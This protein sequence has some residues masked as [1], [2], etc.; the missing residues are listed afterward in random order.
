MNF[1]VFKHLNNL[2]ANLPKGSLVLAGLLTAAVSSHGQAVAGAVVD[3]F[4]ANTNQNKFLGYTFFY[5]DA[6]DGGNSIVASST[7]GGPGELLFDPA[8]STDEGAE[9]SDKSLKLEFTYGDTQPKGCAGTCAY[10][11]M[12]GVGT[13]F[14]P[15]TDGGKVIDLTG[16]TSLTFMAKASVSMIIRVEVTTKNVTDFGYFRAEPTIGPT[17]APVTI[18]LIKDPLG[19][20]SRPAWAEMAT[21]D[22]P[23]D[24]TQVQ[25]LQFQVSADDNPTLTA[26]TL[27]IDN[28][29]VN[30]YNWV[31]PSACIACSGALTP[32]TGA[33]LSDLEDVVAPPRA[34]NMNAVGGFWY[35]YN[36]VSQRTAP[37]PGDYSE[38]FQGADITDPLLP[39]FT[40]SAAKGANASAGAHIGFTLGKTFEENG[41]TIKPFVGLGTKVSDNL[42]VTFSNFTGST[43][44][45][46]D[47]MTSATSTFPYI[48]LEAKANQ[49][50]GTNTGAVHHLLLPSTA[51][52][53]KTATVLWSQLVL[54]DWEGVVA[55][56]LDVTKMDKFQ[57]AVEG[58]PSQEGELSIDNVRITGMTAFTP[59]EVGILPRAGKNLPGLKMAQ[60]AGRIQVAYA[61][62]AGVE[63]AELNILDMKGS[64][65]ESRNLSR[66][67]LL[68][69]SV[70]TKGM[71]SGLYVL[72][73][74][75]AKSVGS[76][77]FTLLK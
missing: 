22:V 76:M 25:K 77:P 19:G 65:V 17:W 48:R 60:V 56:P 59:L 46:F 1:M 32:K 35:V 3:D 20:V 61:L 42:G 71:R 30:G 15:G 37:A 51:G 26:G 44:I 54:P 45:T 74:R 41:E 50:L 52:V 57:W 21:P 2:L 64:V 5:N 40:V 7:P 43:G 11:Q 29:V 14:T 24:L 31:P 47:Y 68:Q 8:K 23:F 55:A 13:E 72:Q 16:A 70:D 28:I 36:D 33:L 49:V 63:T 12:V 66:K 4:E 9:G 18:M 62:P 6:A 75:S 53:W 27:W 34:G 38:I 69:A 10:G 67:E 39:V 73:V 58:T